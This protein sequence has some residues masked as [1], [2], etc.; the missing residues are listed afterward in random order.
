[1]ITKPDKCQLCPFYKK[2]YGF[3]P[4][5]GEGR[6][7]LLVDAQPY[8]YEQLISDRQYTGRSADVMQRL[9]RLTKTN[10]DQFAHCKVV[11]CLTPCDNIWDNDEIQ[12]AIEYC[13]YAW[14]RPLVDKAKTIVPLGHDALTAYIHKPATEKMRGYTYPMGD[15][16]VFGT[17]SP[18]HVGLGNMHLLFTMRH[19]LL[20]VLEGKPFA[21]PKSKRLVEPTVEEFE[22]FAAMCERS[23]WVVVDIETA[24]SGKED[25]A[26][27]LGTSGTITRVSFCCAEDPDY[28]VSV[29]WEIPYTD[30]ARRILALGNDKVFWNTFFDVPHLVRAGFPVNGTHVDAMYLWHFLQP[31]LPMGLAHVA[32]YYTDLPEW[33]SLSAEQPEY[34]SECDAYA[35]GQCYLGVTEHLK[36]LGML[37]IANQ[38]VVQLMM[39][40]ERMHKRGMRINTHALAKLRDT[41]EAELQEFGKSLQSLY[42]EKLLKVKWYKG[43]PKEIKAG[44]KPGDSKLL[45]GK[46]VVFVQ[47]SDGKWGARSEFNP[48]SATNLI[49][50]LKHKGYK[51]P[52]HY[53]T[54]RDTTGAKYLTRIFNKTH[55]PI[56]GGVLEWKERDKI[57][58]TYTVWPVDNKGFVHPQLTLRPATGRLSCVRPNFQNIPKEGPIAD[59]LREC[60]VAREGHVL[61]TADFTGLEMNIT[62]ILAGDELVVKLSTK[63]IYTYVMA[64]FMR[65]GL[66]DDVDSEEFAMLLNQYKRQD[67]VMYKRFKCAVLGISYLEGPRTLFE[68]N[69]G[70]FESMSEASKLRRFVLDTFPKIEKWQQ[71]TIARAAKEKRLFNPYRYV[72]WFFDVPGS[73]SPKAVAQQPQSIGAAMV[74]GD[75]LIFDSDTKLGDCMV[76]QI[77]DELVFDVPKGF[78]NAAK[79]IIK[80]VMERPRPELGGRHITVKVKSGPN[81]RDLS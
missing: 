34:Y 20:A 5:Q 8:E 62:G 64:K 11:Q 79:A 50:Y 43:I 7:I 21:P 73:E 72:R 54:K 9:Y 25:E 13:N 10:H 65:W 55:D 33:K 17:Y 48:N 66:P 46:P 29:A 42:P 24:W 76:L 15:K 30:T 4:P 23:K 38:H 37:D 32:T 1:M 61:V 18:A 51:V 52:Q 75:M 56:I 31:D 81:L 67:D 22:E 80:R 2:G 71:D 44:A 3:L 69:P 68:Q 26:E 19:D 60:I 45:G 12:E 36:S 57:K 28:A 16:R 27:L 70:V 47:G 78:V 63:N 49:D 58:N 77:H 35:E 74:K 59:M 41:L 6:E 40:L 53:K 14:V 39:V